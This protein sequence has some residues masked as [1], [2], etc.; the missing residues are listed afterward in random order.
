VAR[1]PLSDPE[2]PLI[3][4]KAARAAR[5]NSPKHYVA[6]RRMRLAHSHLREN[7]EPLSAVAHRFG[8][9]SEAAFG[10]AFRRTFGV[11]PGAPR[12]NAN[13]FRSPPNMN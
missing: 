9:R 7:A 10:R 8:Y 12:E 6:Q 1:A 4:W 13:P 5:Q 2:I 3:S 11:P